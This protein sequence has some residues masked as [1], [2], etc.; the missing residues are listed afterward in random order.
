MKIASL[1][2]LTASLAVLA[3][4]Q[5]ATAAPQTYTFDA[6]NF[7]AGESTPMLNRAPNIGDA[8]FRTDFTAG[9]TPPLSVLNFQPNTLFSGLSL[10]S[11]SLSLST[12]TMTFNTPVDAVAFDFAIEFSGL[13][14]RVDSSAEDFDLPAGVVGGAFSGGAA[15]LQFSSAISSLVLSVVGPLGA[16]ASGFA[17]DDLVLQSVPEPS[18]LGLAAVALL[19]LT[20]RRR[21]P[22]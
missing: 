12:L 11:P 2:S 16:T 17:I 6:P 22:R 8:S 15:N 3:A 14:L 1:L 21:R 4:L 18:A 5:P 9:T 20:V 10:T 7:A 13:T 19:G